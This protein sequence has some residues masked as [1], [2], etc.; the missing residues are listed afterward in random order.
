MNYSHSNVDSGEVSYHRGGDFETLKGSGIG[1][2]SW[3]Y[4]VGP[5]VRVGWTYAADGLVG[6]GTSRNLGSLRSSVPA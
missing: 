6:L 4:A 3:W 2:G 1:P 5:A